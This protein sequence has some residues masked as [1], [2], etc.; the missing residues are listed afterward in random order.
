M[1][2]KY[3]TFRP[4]K[5]KVNRRPNSYSGS[6]CYNRWG[7]LILLRLCSTRNTTTGSGSAAATH[8]PLPLVELLHHVNE[9]VDWAFCNVNGHSPVIQLAEGWCHMV[10]NGRAGNRTRDIQSDGESIISYISNF[11]QHRH[12]PRF[13]FYYSLTSKHHCLLIF[14]TNLS[15]WEDERLSWSGLS[16][17]ALLRVNKVVPPRIEP[18]TY[19]SRNRVNHSATAKSQILADGHLSFDLKDRAG[20]LLY[21]SI[22]LSFIFQYCFEG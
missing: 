18:A 16:T 5:D 11:Q 2:S 9:G 15:T 22:Y 8:S 21:F 4:L 20:P 13:V 6:E 3:P 10:W 12:A 1:Y 19:R 7:L 14:A 17:R